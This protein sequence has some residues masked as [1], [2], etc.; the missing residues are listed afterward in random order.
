MAKIRILVADDY[1]SVRKGV[2]AILTTRDDVEVCAEAANGE[3]AVHQTKE[4]KPDIVIMDFSMPVMDGLEASKRILQE[5]PDMPI[6]MFSMHKMEAL[7][8]AAKEAGLR[9]FITKGESAQ[10]LLRAVDIV[11]RGEPYFVL[12]S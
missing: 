6:L 11:L 7:T 2:C 12:E 4:L 9:G 8:T 10:N 1:E 5:F 3:E